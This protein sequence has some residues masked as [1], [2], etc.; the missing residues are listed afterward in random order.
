MM[1]IIIPM[2]V[3]N[4][5]QLGH[6]GVFK[7]AS[8][9]SLSHLDGLNCLIDFRHSIAS[10]AVTHRMAPRRSAQNPE[11]LERVCPV[12]ILERAERGG[13]RCLLV[14][15]QHLIDHNGGMLFCGSL[16]FAAVRPIDSLRF[17]LGHA[18]EVA[19]EHVERQQVVDRVLDDV[20]Y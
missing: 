7:L 5:Q 19:L 12:G 2:I 10:Q 14:D 11:L 1:H 16:L 4:P 8:M 13:T 17:C 6:Q 15:D 20:L 18:D 3:L 9:V